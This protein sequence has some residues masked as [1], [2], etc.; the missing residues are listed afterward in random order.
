MPTA[1]TARYAL[2]VRDSNDEYDEEA[3]SLLSSTLM[4][5]TVASSFAGAATAGPV[6]PPAHG[7]E[8]SALS[9]AAVATN[10]TSYVEPAVLPRF[11]VC[12]VHFE[13]GGKLVT[14]SSNATIKNRLHRPLE[15][16]LFVLHPCPPLHAESAFDQRTDTHWRSR[17]GDGAR[18]STAEYRYADKRPR[19]V[20]VYSMASGPPGSNTPCDW[21]LQGL[22]LPDRWVPID[23]RRGESFTRSLQVRSFDVGNAA[24]FAAYRLVVSR[25]A[26]ICSTATAMLTRLQLQLRSK[27]L[28]SA[29]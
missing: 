27:S 25:V 21:S 29:T 7:G 15:L 10:A 17:L 5:P 12:D 16:S 6:A 18:D 13:E 28:L 1:T 8:S 2:A 3:L 22:E 26:P 11:I 24:P 9:A 19:T 14:V 20:V 23:S 4:S